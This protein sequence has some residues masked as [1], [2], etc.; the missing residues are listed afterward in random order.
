MNEEPQLL[1]LMS[2]NHHDLEVWEVAMELVEETYLVTK[3]LPSEEKYGLFS[4][5]RRA[6][7]SI[8]SNIAEGK[9]RS[10]KKDFRSFLI[11]ARSSTCELQTQLEICERLKFFSVEK[12]QKSKQLIERVLKMSSSLIRSLSEN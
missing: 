9:S 2:F 10:S 3:L 7:V 8:P 12:A 5:M 1:L 6:A 4:Q 11:Y